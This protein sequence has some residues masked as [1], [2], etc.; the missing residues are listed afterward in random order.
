MLHF[1]DQRLQTVTFTEKQKDELTWELSQDANKTAIVA[2]ILAN[3]EAL[4]SLK[5]DVHFYKYPSVSHF[6]LFV[7]LKE[8]ESGAT[9]YVHR[10]EGFSVDELLKADFL[11]AQ[12]EDITYDSDKVDV[13]KDM[14]IQFADKGS[15]SVPRAIRF[16]SGGL[17]AL[18]DGY[19]V[20]AC[21]YLQRAVKLTVNASP[22]PPA[23][24]AIKPEASVKV[25]TM[26]D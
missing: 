22:S 24:A 6:V 1:S 26:D 25:E 14:E 9:K 20:Y 11:V 16:W 23:A 4:K 5:K 7:A 15:S 10:R 19:S 21:K 18:C 3:V 8:P 13:V 12:P 2:A 17:Y